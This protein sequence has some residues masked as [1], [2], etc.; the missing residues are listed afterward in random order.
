M[1]V[2]GF[3]QVLFCI[4]LKTLVLH[5]TVEAQMPRRGGNQIAV[6]G[7]T[8]DSHYL[9]RSFDEDK[10]VV[11]KSFDIKSGKGVIVPLEISGRDILA[12]QLPQGTTLAA[13]D[14]I[15]PDMK[16]YIDKR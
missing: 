14:V 13:N 11:I 16:S 9:F 3:I 2:P 5:N 12:G 8:D 1:K 4:V 7:W 15:S 10:N 6:I